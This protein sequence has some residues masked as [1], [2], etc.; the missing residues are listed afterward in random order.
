MII[1]KQKAKKKK[2]KFRVIIK[3]VEDNDDDSFKKDHIIIDGSKIK[4]KN[5]HKSTSYK[6]DQVIHLDDHFYNE[7]SPLIDNF[8][9]GIN[10]SIMIF[11]SK[12]SKKMYCQNNNEISST[13]IKS[14]FEKVD[15]KI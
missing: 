3:L 2:N 7:I 12:Y 13:V 1:F 14:I 11:G 10:S 8:L 15:Q 5:K 6:F 9:C 4:I